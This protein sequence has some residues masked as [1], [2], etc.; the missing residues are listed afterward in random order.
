MTAVDLEV[1]LNREVQAMMQRDKVPGFAVAV[2]KDGQVLFSKGYGL[3][4]VQ[5]GIPVNPETTMFRVASVSKLMTATAV[6]Q[7]VEQGKLSM[8]ADVTPQLDFSLHRKYPQ[9]VTLRQLLTHTAGFEEGAFGMS[10]NDPAQLPGLR[11]SLASTIPQQIQAPGSA[12]SYSNHG[13]ALAGHLVERSSGL[14]FAE[15]AENKLFAPL[16]MHHTT[17]RETIAAG[18]AKGYQWEEGRF[19]EMPPQYVGGVEPAGALRASANDMA[20]FMLMQLRGGQEGVLTKESAQAMQSKQFS[21][22]VGANSDMGYGFARYHANGVQILTHG[23]DLRDFRSELMLLPEKGVGVFLTCN[24]GSCNNLGPLFQSLLDRYYPAPAPVSAKSF[25]DTSA[26]YKGSYRLFRSVHEN[27]LK[28][29]WI[30]LEYHVEPAG[31]HELKF[32]GAAFG[33]DRTGH[34]RQQGHTDSGLHGGDLTFVKA[35]DQQRILFDLNPFV[36]AYR[37]SWYETRA[38][39]LAVAAAALL[40]VL[41]TAWLGFRQR[42]TASPVLQRQRLLSAASLGLG[43]LGWIGMFVYVLASGVLDTGFGFA[44]PWPV[45]VLL[46]LPLLAILLALFSLRPLAA[47]MADAAVPRAARLWAG[48][49]VPVMAALFLVMAYWKLIGFQY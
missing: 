6:L 2:V 30:A 33:Q 43:L 38:C 35:G 39:A 22:A 19:V 44:V 13:V 36:F 46:C 27:F 9:P 47:L 14:P 15:Y 7:Q 32:D 37:L 28:F 24:S 49:S 41:A 40:Q 4:D 17:F 10:V 29:M 26:D 23:G 12:I 45:T 3:E 25:A 48:M 8:D 18:F 20:R 31:P 16:A 1:F 11:Q 42:A 5:K 34:F 21:N